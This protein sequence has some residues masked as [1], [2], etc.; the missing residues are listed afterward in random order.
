MS[1]LTTTLGSFFND[2][3]LEFPLLEV[4]WLFALEFIVSKSPPP[5][6][7]SEFKTLLALDIIRSGFLGVSRS[8][9]LFGSLDTIDDKEI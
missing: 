2:F 9:Y 8:C 1:P 5:K 6:L 4:N 3:I 7:A